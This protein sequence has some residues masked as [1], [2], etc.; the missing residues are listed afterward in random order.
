MLSDTWPKHPFN[1]IYKNQVKSDC[2]WFERTH[3]SNSIYMQQ[4]N[5]LIEELKSEYYRIKPTIQSSLVSQLM[6]LNDFSW[7]II[8]S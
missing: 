6:D 5:K 7:F 2:E 8:I 1:H 4:K 3:A